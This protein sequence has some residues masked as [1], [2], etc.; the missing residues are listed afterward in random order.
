MQTDC[1]P[2]FLVGTCAQHKG[3]VTRKK[4]RGT[5]KQNSITSST[6]VTQVA[7]GHARQEQVQHTFV[8]RQTLCPPQPH[9]QRT[10]TLQP[11]P[12]PTTATHT[13]YH[14]TTAP[15]TAHHNPYL[16][17]C[18]PLLAPPR[19][20][21]ADGVHVGC[22]VALQPVVLLHPVFQV[23]AVPV[24]MEGHVAAHL[25]AVGAVNDNA[26]E[27]RPSGWGHGACRMAVWMASVDG[28]RML[29]P[30]VIAAGLCMC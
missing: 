19:R 20:R 14:H 22:Q 28:K 26:A 16:H 30:C 7:G 29:R 2:Y 8:T 13:T 21:L 25:K 4:Q 1:F 17:V 9:T 15:P 6:K 18:G 24:D 3:P 27:V 12:V 5:N 11:T 10:T 23:E